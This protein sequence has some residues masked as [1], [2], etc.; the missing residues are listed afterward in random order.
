MK[1]K[2]K[3]IQL[4]VITVFVLST[5]VVRSLNVHI[6]STKDRPSQV[7]SRTKSAFRTKGNSS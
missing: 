3:T 5:Y 6:F 4:L 1:K 2:P 7:I